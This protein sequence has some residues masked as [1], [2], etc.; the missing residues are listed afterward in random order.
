QNMPFPFWDGNPFVMNFWMFM[1]LIVLVG[2]FFEYKKSVV[3][4]RMHTGH[5]GR[6]LHREL[7][8]IR[9]RLDALE[10]DPAA[11]DP[12]SLRRRVEVLERIVTDRGY[13]LRDEFSRLEP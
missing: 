8:E 3:K 7:E 6:A 13:Q 11:R 5:D 2:C 9:R 1:F 4:M 12:G 10:A